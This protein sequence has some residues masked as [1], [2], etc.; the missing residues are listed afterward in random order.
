MLK[1]I[2]INTDT[3]KKTIFSGYANKNPKIISHIYAN[4]AG[5]IKD[6]T[7]RRWINNKGKILVVKKYPKIHRNSIYFPGENKQKLMT[8]GN[9]FHNL[10]TFTLIVWVKTTSVNTFLNTFIEVIPK[11]LLMVSSLIKDDKNIQKVMKNY[12]MFTSNK[13][14]IGVAGYSNINRV[15]INKN[16]LPNEYKK[17]DWNHILVAYKDQNICY[18][19]NGSKILESDI[20]YNL[21]SLPK[22]YITI[23]GGD[24]LSDLN[25][26][27][28]SNMYLNEFILYDDLLFEFGLNKFTVPKSKTTCLLHFL[29]F[30][31]IDT[32]RKITN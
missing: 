31:T 13:L 25:Q 2:I 4:K 32:E 10:T 1:S 22:D 20:K 23:I 9:I 15:T 24:C 16:K 11:D 3:C 26:S 6:A 12:H 29:P 28:T 17:S 5:K 7:G 8:N 18:Y 21:A 19:I 27:S 30:N 14:G